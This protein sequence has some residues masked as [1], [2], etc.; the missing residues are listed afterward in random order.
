MPSAA[1]QRFGSLE[2]GSA[3]ILRTLKLTLAYDG[4]AYAGWQVQPGQPTVQ[5][6]LE[7][8]IEKVTGERV[9]TLASGRTDAGVHALG[10][11][12]GWRTASKLPVDVLR[13][14]IHAQLPD[15]VAVLALAEVAEGFHAIRDAVSKRYRYLIHD[16][17]VRDV[18]RRRYCWDYRHGRLDAT[19]MAR[20]AEA[21]R[22]THDFRSFQS[23]GAERESTV[24]TIFDL[25]VRR[26]RGEA[27]ED[28]TSE[29]DD[30]ITIEVEADGFLY[31]M[32]RAIVGTLVEVGRG[33]RDEAGRPRSFGQP[34]GRPLAPPRRRRDCS[35]CGSNTIAAGEARGVS[36]DDGWHALACVGMWTDVASS[37]YQADGAGQGGRRGPTPSATRRAADVP[38]A[39]EATRSGRRQIGHQMTFKRRRGSVMR[40][41][42]VITRLILGGA[43][44]NTVLCCEDLVRSGDDVLLITGPPLGPEGSLL[45]RARAG[46]VPIE[47]IDALRRPIHPWRDLLSYRR[48]QHILGDFRPDVVHTHSAKGG[49]LGRAAAW[50]LGVPAVVHTVHGAPFHPYQGRA[51]RVASQACE[52]WAARRCHAIVS[53]ADAM[54]DLMVAARVAP[55]EMFST[56]YSG[57]EVEPFLD[58]ARHRQRVRQELGYDSQHVVVGKIARLF[59]LKGHHDVIRAFEQLVGTEP[60]VRLLLVGDGILRPA[61]CREIAA[62]GLSDRVHLTGLVP[63]ERIPE[64]IAAMDVVVHA[65]LREGLAR[66]L[67]QAL[68]AGRPV[69][70][71][72]VDG[73]RE[74]VIS[75]ETGFLVP[76][77]DIDALA[78][79]LGR[80]VGDAR[81]REQLGR[82]GRE[83]FT[84][85][86]RH[87]R[88]TA[89][90][91][92]L[93][94]RLLADR[95]PARRPGHRP[96]GQVGKAGGNG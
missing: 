22:G 10:Q 21:L 42:H 2:A 26:G 89:E 80:L 32:V 60:R 86:F 24:R 65:S 14:A 41:A 77:R 7:A 37:R 92:A 69:V 55:R 5:V 85:T 9:R 3:G 95:P 83:R 28:G 16:G 46:G 96:D 56:V 33:T 63:P 52:R 71:Y 8:A 68:I 76:P 74:V 53:V 64:L 59:H 91:R 18:F 79:A 72:D 67:P 49:I 15:D 75:G 38:S 73:A 17:P 57:M 23:S 4:A 40:I 11:V 30:W 81:L 54:T 27:G 36:G 51:G 61:I 44:E 43:Q 70:S 48:I 62:A 34:I 12:V 45:Q 50:S 31:N 20:A 87:E 88:M 78:A 47:V 93:Y 66:V 1:K 29:D 19:A 13:R 6:T 58:S 94:V 90:L 39:A 82:E 84:E 25:P 35:W